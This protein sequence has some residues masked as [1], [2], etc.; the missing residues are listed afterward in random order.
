MTGR[1]PLVRGD[2]GLPE[3]LQPGDTL[4]GAGSGSGT[5]TNLATGIGLTGGPI[6]TTGTVALANT[7]V[8]PNTY[9]D[10]A[11]V[12]QITVDQQGRIT[13]ASSVAITAG[14]G[15]LTNLATGTGLT[16]GPITTTG[17]IALANTAVS[18]NTYGDSAHVSQFT[19]DQQGR[20][21]AASSVAITAGSGTLTNLATGT[22]LTGGPITTTGTIALANTAVS[23]NTYGDSAHVSQITVDQ[24]GRITSA[25]SV[26]ITGG[27]GVSSVSNSDGTLV[28]SPTTG[29]VVASARVA[30]SSVTGIV[31]PDN[32]TITISAGVI[33]AAGGGG[34]SSTAINLGTAYGLV[35]DG[36]KAF[37]A[38]SSSLPTDNGPAFLNMMG[39]NEAP[40][41]T[42]TIPS[43]KT[44]NPDYG[45]A[46]PVL[47]NTGTGVIS[48]FSDG[49][50]TVPVAH[51]LR[52]GDP[53]V[54]FIGTTGALPTPLVALKICYASYNNMAISSF[55][56]TD[57]NILGIF[58]SVSNAGPQPTDIALGGSPSN[59]YM[60]TV[61][62][63]WMNFVVPP[64]SYYSS[65]TV[66]RIA[67][68]RRMRVDMTGVTIAGPNGFSVGF[69]GPGLSGGFYPQV[70]LPFNTAPAGSGSIT[71]KNSADASF[72]TVGGMLCLGAGSLQDFPGSPSTG[73]PNV[74]TFE[75]KRIRDISGGVISFGPQS[76]VGSGDNTLYG[77]SDT[78]PMFTPNDGLCAAGAAMAYPCAPF[79]D[80]EIMLI[81]ARNAQYSIL[82]SQ[83]AVSGR[84]LYITGLYSDGQG[85]DTTFAEDVVYDNIRNG[86]G[87]E[88][89][90]IDKLVHR[91]TVQ[92]SRDVGSIQIEG[93]GPN[94]MTVRQSSP[95]QI[96]GSAK[97][98]ILDDVDAG[99]G[100]LIG[101]A[102]GAT[103]EL[104]VTGSHLS[105][106]FTA[107]RSGDSPASGAFNNMVNTWSFSGG[108]LSKPFPLIGT[109]NTSWMITGKPCFVNNMVT[110][111][112]LNDP[113]IANM[114]APFKIDDV[115]M[116]FSN[117]ATV[118]VSGGGGSPADAVVTWT[119]SNPVANGDVVLFPLTGSLGGAAPVSNTAP[120]TGLKLCVPYWAVGVSALTHKLAAFMNGPPIQTTGAGASSIIYRNPTFSI[121]TTLPSIPVGWQTSGTVTVSHGSPI[122]V[123]ASSPVAN[124]TYVAFTTT[125]QLPAT[126]TQL[127][128][129]TACYI[130]GNLL[131][132]GGF[133]GPGVGPGIAVIGSGVTPGTFITGAGTGAGGA[134]TYYVN[135]SQT[136]ASSGSPIAMTFNVALG[137]VMT[138]PFSLA[139]IGN[140]QPVEYVTLGASGNTYNLS[141]DGVTA[142]NG[143][144]DASAA[145]SGTHT[146]VTRPL[147]FNPHPC[148]CVTV[149][150]SSGHPNVLDHRSNPQQGLPFNSY[151]DRNFAGQLSALAPDIG[152]PPK[153]WGNLI[154][155]VISVVKADTTSGGGTRT[156]MIGGIKATFTGTAGSPSTHIN[157]TA[158][159]GVICAGDTLIGT[160]ITAGT[161]VVSQVSGPPGGAGEYVLSAANTTSAAAVTAYGCN[162]FDSGLN[163]ADFSAT[164][165]L[166]TTGTRTITA[167]S[168]TTSATLGADSFAFYTGWFSDQI[169]FCTPDVIGGQPMSSYAQ[170]RVTIQT[171]Q[172]IYTTPISGYARTQQWST[173]AAINDTIMPG[174]ATN[175]GV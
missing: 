90:I 174:V 100:I 4:L 94:K 122:V 37:D 20:I 17:T 166:L 144:S 139:V 140:A 91:V 38:G 113:Q 110:G 88:A 136:V 39:A 44:I 128:A 70:G 42:G 25:S 24:Q 2:N 138:T 52:V 66:F 96:S 131:T 8:S 26:A 115:Y 116:G 161:K 86:P 172:G 93:A 101:P 105:Q 106:F 152:A 129:G 175:T 3:Q 1:L 61:N 73:N 28:I 167:V 104:I 69:G 134:G 58:C 114:G 46:V 97:T 124:G 62:A 64:G 164:I 40:L 36:Y 50:R 75:F 151:G 171:D 89:L 121:A 83:F 79:F 130:T 118:S 87:R 71:L 57:R 132:I 29:A 173:I 127:G 157:A 33:S 109:G 68:P 120:P 55:K 9:G 170:I 34:G 48:C 27:S 45:P 13:S 12:S 135:N 30:T 23:P 32:S 160:G 125:G 54:F 7:A 53:V 16:G 159:T 99:Q 141:T 60:A 22:G 123:T 15:T 107:V 150:G 41:G 143:A 76:L 102:F 119:G 67:G 72:F 155:M 111:I 10:S 63:D 6:T 35:A 19:V 43:L 165:D 80:A 51:Q 84:Y 56:V 146:A 77:Y 169:N 145:G 117:S 153:M 18:P 103:D 112:V 81:N 92:N 147:K 49:A 163:I 98:M 149:I 82:G 65:A 148:P 137:S 21:T 11:H 14:S 154:K 168:G 126:A 78:L 156:L 5:L 142:I 74:Q 47:I 59:V 162:G 31:K 133:S 85:P 158:I 108:V 95:L